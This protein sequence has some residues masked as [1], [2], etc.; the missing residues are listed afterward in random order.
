MDDVKKPALTLRKTGLRLLNER[1]IEEV[2]GG[3]NGEVQNQAA[4]VTY[5]CPGSPCRTVAAI[6]DQD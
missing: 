6:L 3:N 5:S 4:G 2:V 1:E